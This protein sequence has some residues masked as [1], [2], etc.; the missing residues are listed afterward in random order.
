[1]I[2]ED[3]PRLVMTGITIVASLVVCILLVDFYYLIVRVRTGFDTMFPILAIMPTIAAEVGFALAMPK[4]YLTVYRGGRLPALFS[5]VTAIQLT[6]LGLIRV[7]RVLIV[8]GATTSRPLGEA[9][10]AAILGQNHVTVTTLF[11]AGAVLMLGLTI[12]FHQRG[13]RNPY[14]RGESDFHVSRRSS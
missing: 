2:R 1:M 11:F 4:H 14:A 5:L 9:Q 7:A 8:R 3:I 6:I 13:R 12:F 10:I